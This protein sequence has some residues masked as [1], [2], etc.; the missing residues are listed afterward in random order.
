MG[1]LGCV[2]DAETMCKGLE[3]REIGLFLETSQNMTGIYE[4]RETE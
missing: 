3:V 2:R 4:E 1:R